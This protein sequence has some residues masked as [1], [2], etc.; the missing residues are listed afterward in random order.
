MGLDMIVVEGRTLRLGATVPHRGPT[1]PLEIWRYTLDERGG[2]QTG[3]CVRVAGRPVPEV[4][5]DLE[6]ALSAEDLVDEYFALGLPYKYDLDRKPYTPMDWPENCRWI[7]CYATTGGSEGH[8]VNVDIILDNG[9][10]GKEADW[11]RVS[12]ATIKTFKGMEHA[13]KIA[14]RCADLLGA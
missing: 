10:Q 12:I 3:R 11:L 9:K 2:E 13:R 14:A 4:M 5:A 1:I 7:A 6:R 8:Y